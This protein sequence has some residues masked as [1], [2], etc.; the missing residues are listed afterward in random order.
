MYNEFLLMLANAL[1][2][3]FPNVYVA[4]GDDPANPL[5]ADTP[6]IVLLPGVGGAINLAD[7]AENESVPFEI[8]FGVLNSEFT[9]TSDGAKVL[10]GFASLDERATAILSTIRANTEG[11]LSRADYNADCFQFPLFTAGISCEVVL[12]DTF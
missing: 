5:E 12:S 6:Y 8:E 10:S 4:F 7:T 3:A 9:Y 2:I 11:Y 1:K